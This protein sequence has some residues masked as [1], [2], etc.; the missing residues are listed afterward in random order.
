MLDEIAAILKFLEDN[1]DKKIEGEPTDE[2]LIAMANLELQ[3]IA[4]SQAYFIALEREGLTDEEVVK[5]MRNR[6]K[7]GEKDRHVFDRLTKMGREVHAI[8]RAIERAV[9]KTRQQQSKTGRT[10]KRKKKRV[11]QSLGIGF[12][13]GWKRL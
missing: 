13:K 2:E 9:M 4:A 10:Y 7:M 6:D 12:R 5:M 8:H 1:K 11:N 3:V